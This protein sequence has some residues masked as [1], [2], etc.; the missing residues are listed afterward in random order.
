MASSTT[1]PSLDVTANALKDLGVWDDILPDVNPSQLKGVLEIK[2]PSGV[3]IYP[4]ATPHRDEVQ[5]EPKAYFHGEL[6]S[7]AKYTLLLTDPDLMKTNDPIDKEVRHWVQPGLSYSSSTG[8]LTSSRGPHTSFLP[9]AP[10][11]M[12]GSHRYIFILAK[13]S[14]EVGVGDRDGE[15]D[16]KERLRFVA[17][18]FITEHGLV[19][20]G[21]TAMKVAPTAEAG[22]DDIKLM[23]ESAK[24][25]VTG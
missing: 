10:M 9:S 19:V 2:Y 20:V 21:V 12:T 25:L 13:E 4:V 11:P 17:Q 1:V 7:N 5:G 6:D 15:A 14:R 3:S 8:E 18:D 22:K 16:F 23:A 24:H